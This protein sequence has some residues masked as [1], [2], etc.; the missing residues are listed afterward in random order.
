MVR[1]ADADERTR[2]VVRQQHVELRLRALRLARRRSHQDAQ[3]DGGQEPSGPQHA[4]HERPPRLAFRDPATIQRTISAA[5]PAASRCLIV[6]PLTHPAEGEDPPVGHLG[7]LAERVDRD[8]GESGAVGPRAREQD[9]HQRDEQHRQEL[10]EP[11]G[12][13]VVGAAATRARLPRRRAP[14]APAVRGRPATLT[15]SPITTARTVGNSADSGSRSHT[16][17]AL[18]GAAWYQAEPSPVSSEADGEDE[19]GHTFPSRA[20]PSAPS[21][22][23]RPGAGERGSR[24]WRAR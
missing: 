23:E 5:A 17:D 14:A 22:S 13:Q 4:H 7:H 19:A 24:R 1:G 3:Q 21:A 18:L 20:A 10:G 12:P 11:V 9:Q 15:R 8:A 6:W 16:S 2:I